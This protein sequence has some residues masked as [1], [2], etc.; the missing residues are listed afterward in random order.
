M[1][2]AICY[3]IILISMVVLVFV[4]YNQQKKKIRIEEAPAFDFF[5][6]RVEEIT[7]D[8]SEAVFEDFYSFLKKYKGGK[9]VNTYEN[10]ISFELLDSEKESLGTMFISSV[11]PNGNISVETKE[12][13]RHF[14]INRGVI[15]IREMPNYAMS[16]A[17]NQ[18]RHMG[19]INQSADGKSVTDAICSLTS[20]DYEIFSN[21]RIVDNNMIR[22]YSNIVIGNNGLFLIESISNSANEEQREKVFDEL[23]QQKVFLEKILHGYMVSIHPIMACE[24]DVVITQTDGYDI[25][26]I[27]KLEKYIRSYADV[28]PENDKILMVG[29]IKKRIW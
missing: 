28:V 14:L 24:S 5:R 26:N 4:F 11:V 27:N 25:V 22:D 8:C 19:K 29:E 23:K 17:I 16:I 1:I 6:R 13:Y 2:L 10:R 9:P 21:I 18:E 12:E 3:V 20:D 15:G 7:F